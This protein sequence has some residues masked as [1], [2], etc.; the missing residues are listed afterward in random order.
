MADPL[1]VINHRAVFADASTARVEDPEG[2][3]LMG[4][5]DITKAIDRAVLWVGNR[6]D[7]GSV[8]DLVNALALALVVIAAESGYFEESNNG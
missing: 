3:A 5:V 2:R 4:P 8:T 1:L 7:H 6:R